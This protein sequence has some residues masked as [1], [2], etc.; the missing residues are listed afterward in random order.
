MDKEHTKRGHAPLLN[1]D[2]DFVRAACCLPACMPTTF[3]PLDHKKI[4]NNFETC[5]EARLKAVLRGTTDPKGRSL[6]F[7]AA[8]SQLCQLPFGTRQTQ[9]PYSWPESKVNIFVSHHATKQ[10]TS[11]I[12]T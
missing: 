3:Q 1:K 5:L 11:T 9:L 4:G 12:P 6:T 10:N 7:L 2:N 8:F